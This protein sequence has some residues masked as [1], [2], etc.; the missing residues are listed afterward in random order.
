MRKLLQ[1]KLVVSALAGVAALSVAANFVKLPKR[2]SLAAAREPVVNATDAPPVSL[3]VPGETEFS[4]TV[5]PWRELFPIDSAVR[6]PFAALVQPGPTIPA[7]AT[8]TATSA[9]PFQPTETPVFVLQAVSIE[10]NRP[11]AVINQTVVAEG[12]QISGYRVESIVSTH[13]TL[14]GSSGSVVVS[15]GRTALRQKTPT[16]AAPAADLPPATIR[17]KTGAPTVE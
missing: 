10:A 14:S 11:F 13:V 12:D 7:T 6:D 5:R 8:A 1:N 4:R 16:G 15:M 3:S 17:P 9:A 2:L